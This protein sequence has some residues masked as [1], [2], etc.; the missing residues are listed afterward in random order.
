M[1]NAARVCKTKFLFFVGLF[2]AL[3]TCNKCFVLWR[4]LATWRQKK[5]RKK[6][7]RIQQRAF[8]EFSLKD[9]HILRKNKKT[10]AR[11]CQIWTV[12]LQVAR[13]RQ[14]SKKDLLVH[15]DSRHLLLI[16]AEDISQC[17]Y[18]RNLRKKKKK[19][20]L[21][22]LLFSKKNLFLLPLYHAPSS[23]YRSPKPVF[24]FFFSKCQMLH[25]CL[26]SQGGIKH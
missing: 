18:L 23:P 25:H 22:S 6:G 10:K 4:I 14:D 7:W 17:T 19:P 24:L 1:K 12:F 3:R 15:K 21:N 2:N 13:T 11:S 26:E 9:R 16:N 20:M 5:T 8:G